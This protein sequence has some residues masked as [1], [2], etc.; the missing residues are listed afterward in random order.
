MNGARRPADRG[1]PRGAS[2]PTGSTPISTSYR[3]YDVLELPPNTQGIVALEMLNILEGFDLKALGHNSAAY[4]HLLVEAKRIAFADRAAWLGDLDSVPRRRAQ[5]HA[6]EGLRG[7]APQGDR[8]RRARR[9]Y[10][11]L[12]LTPGA[13]RR[14]GDRRRRAATRST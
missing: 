7:G 12:T 11:P 9:D 1:R 13:A 10:K 3:G 4:L 5:T 2:A 14:Q 6:V 8:S